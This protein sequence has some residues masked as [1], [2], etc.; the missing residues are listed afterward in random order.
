MSDPCQGK[1]QKDLDYAHIPM[2]AVIWV[3]PVYVRG[4]RFKS[5]VY[6]F[7]YVCGDDQGNIKGKKWS[8]GSKE[9]AA[10]QGKAIQ[11]V[12]HL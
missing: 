8:M 12:I 9:S 4:Y 11:S 6:H 5:C 3:K 7:S 1:L 2:Y 10:G